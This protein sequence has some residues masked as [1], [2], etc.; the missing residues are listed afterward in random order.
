MPQL[1]D[2]HCHL[3]FDAYQEDREE[4]LARA[5]EVGVERVLVPAIN[6]ASSR[7][8]LAL[9]GDH[10]GLY[11]AV[12]VHPNSA[13]RWTAGRVEELREAAQHPRVKAIGEIGLD[14]YHDRTSHSHQKEVLVSQ[15][16]LASSL[17]LPVVLHVRNAQESDR[18][19][20]IDL[21]DVLSDW[22]TQTAS[23]GEHARGVI[24]SFSGNWQ[25]AQ[26]AL[27]MGFLLGITGPVTFSNAQ[28]MQ[29]VAASAPLEK[30]VIE[31]DGPFLTPQPHRGK[32]NEPA[33]VR[34][35][36]EKISQLQHR[37]LDEVARRT[38]ENAD[39]LFR[40]RN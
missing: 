40:W 9:T 1:V 27:A 13:G 21:L 12:G 29:Q 23:E 10:D 14:Y 3:N 5:R 28:D 4:V 7:Q 11:A 31:T 32:R 2:T 34:F 8:I 37:E 22:C 30:L 6:L 24:H 35:I 38:T 36:A 39:R 20:I 19:C 16:G 18:S 17:N 25:E 15:L 26:R 33:Y